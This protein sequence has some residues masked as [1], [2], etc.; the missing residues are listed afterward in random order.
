[1]VRFDEAAA[2]PVTGAVQPML[3]NGEVGLVWIPRGHVFRVL[4]FSV[5][6]GKI[7]TVDV[8]ADPTRLREFDLAVLD[9]G[10][11]FN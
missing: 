5:A 3:I 1:M 7:A 2:R 9:E 6:D 4:R 10:R 8:I 11:L